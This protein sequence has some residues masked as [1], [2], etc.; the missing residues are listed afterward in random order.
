MSTIEEHRCMRCHADYNSRHIGRYCPL[1]EQ[2][3]N[4][5]YPGYE[6]GPNCIIP[7][8]DNTAQFIFCDGSS[9]G[10]YFYCLHALGCAS[11]PLECLVNLF[12]PKEL[13]TPCHQC[14]DLP[15]CW[16]ENGYYYSK[17]VTDRQSI[18]TIC[19]LSANGEYVSIL[20]K[21][22]FIDET[23]PTHVLHFVCWPITNNLFQSVIK[24]E[25]V[26]M[27]LLFY[28]TGQLAS[29]LIT[30]NSYLQVICADI[31]GMIDDFICGDE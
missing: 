28:L 11:N 27:R 29:Q 25:Y 17:M 18:T 26:D 30:P 13:A 14:V 6:P 3:Y 16:F 5:L 4:I 31:I 23:L 15:G 24:D 12:M 8:C 22:I 2:C 21:N 9:R 20:L 1:C 10:E 19:F 7:G